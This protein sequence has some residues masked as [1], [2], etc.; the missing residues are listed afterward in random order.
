[1]EMR[2]DQTCEFNDRQR[3]RRV[4][5]MAWKLAQHMKPV[6]LMASPRSITA[7]S[8]CFATSGVWRTI[9][10]NQ[11]LPEV[12]RGGRVGPWGTK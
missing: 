11:T 10:P 5:S 6:P 12:A 1:M 3:R 2:H 7:R 4:A 9:A 8:C